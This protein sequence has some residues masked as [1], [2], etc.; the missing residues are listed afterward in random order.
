MS[1]ERVYEQWY[2]VVEE[3]SGEHYPW[4]E[5]TKQGSYKKLERML[6]QDNYYEGDL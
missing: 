5:H 6:G 2:L 4:K 3:M 1:K